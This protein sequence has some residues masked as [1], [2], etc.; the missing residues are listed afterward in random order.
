MKPYQEVINKDNLRLREF[1]I[2]TDSHEFVWHKDE[3]DRYVTIMEGEGWQFQKDNELPSILK[4]G[5]TIFIPKETYHRVIK[6][7]S[8]LLISI[9]EN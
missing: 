7:S 3:K 9:I 1:K 5:D 4:K 8:N 6:G 2:D